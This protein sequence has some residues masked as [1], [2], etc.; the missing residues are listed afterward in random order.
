MVSAVVLFALAAGPHYDGY[1]E[2]DVE[3]PGVIFSLAGFGALTA[4]GWLGGEIVFVHGIRVLARDS[5]SRG[6]PSPRKEAPSI[7]R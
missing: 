3:T 6:E 4:L 2:G 5:G 7:G 1:R